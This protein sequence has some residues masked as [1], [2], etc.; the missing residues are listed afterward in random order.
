MSDFSASYKDKIAENAHQI[1]QALNI[2]Q[3]VWKVGREAALDL[4]ETFLK[5]Y[6]DQAKTADELLVRQRVLD[7]WRQA[8]R[9][10][11]TE[12]T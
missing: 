3:L 12:E 10:T 6:R 9:G 5:I 1:F 11:K 7:K 4:K 2:E 8:W